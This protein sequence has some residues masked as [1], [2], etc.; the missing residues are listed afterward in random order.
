[1]EPTNKWHCCCV[2]VCVSHDVAM[3]SILVVFCVRDKVRQKNH[4][5]S[6]EQV[7]QHSVTRWQHCDRRNWTIGLVSGLGYGL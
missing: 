7:T 6:V 4:T 3:V 2:C 5:A 1:V